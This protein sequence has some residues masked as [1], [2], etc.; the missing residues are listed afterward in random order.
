VLLREM[1]VKGQ[2]RRFDRP[3]MTSGLPDKQTCQAAA[4]MSQTCQIR[5]PHPSFASSSR[6]QS[7]T[8]FGDIYVCQDEGVLQSR[9]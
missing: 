5:C 1:I 2:S 7:S 4:G 6:Q 3:S 9:M 8:A